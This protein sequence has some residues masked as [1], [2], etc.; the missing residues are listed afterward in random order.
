MSDATIGWSD[1][2]SLRRHAS[3]GVLCIALGL[4]GL[5]YWAAVTP[6]AGAVTAGGSVV[7]D[8]GSRKVQHPEGGVVAAIM[9][10]NDDAVVAG[11]PL[12]RLDGT[13]TSASL[14][15]VQSQLVEAFIRRA[16]L[17]AETGAEPAMAW[18]TELDSLPGTDKSQALFRDETRLHDAR[19]RGLD[20]QTAQLNEQINQLN[21]QIRGLVAQAQ[22][23]D[24]EIA[25]V[26]PQ[27]SRFEQLSS[28]KLIGDS[29]LS[30]A[31]RQLAQLDGTKAST[32]AEV[33]RI[34]ATVAERGMQIAQTNDGF[35]GDAL[36]DLQDVNLSIAQLQQQQIAA[37]DR[38]ARLEIRAP[39][40]GIVH[41]STVQTVGGVVGPGDTL[42]QIVPQDAPMMFD[43]RVSPLDIDKLRLGQSVDL[44]LSGV[45]P[46]TTPDLGGSVSRISPD[47][48]RDP[49]NGAQFYLVRVGLPPG[50][51]GKLAPS[52]VNLVP[53]M[54]VQAFLKTTDRTVLAFLLG[55]FLE[56]LSLVFR[57]N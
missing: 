3:L 56:R 34:R 38:L 50:E 30:D 6:I 41:E 25:I 15:L 23:T 47:L 20:N 57:E 9:V 33:A 53:G 8:G 48:S 44:R 11:E 32:Q 40:S 14:A 39:I 7:V 36:K 43:V 42:M 49:G 22:A 24:D 55:P 5:G 21:E 13:T 19:V 52:H 12:V 28:Q 1:V 2:R 51:L 18:P 27:V 31:R 10:R 45:D 37:Q 16:R 4:G 35:L 46:R 54:P 29:Q 26:G 17:L